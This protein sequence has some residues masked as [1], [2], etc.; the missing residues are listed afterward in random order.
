MA[1]GWIVGSYSNVTYSFLAS[2]HGLGVNVEE[3]IRNLLCIDRI[4]F[5]YRLGLNFLAFPLILFHLAIAVLGVEF[6]ILEQHV[7]PL[8]KHHLNPN[9]SL[10]IVYVKLY[11]VSS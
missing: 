9:L 2:K 3:N 1:H 10:G 11:Y 7:I 6:W 4:D 5:S 8:T